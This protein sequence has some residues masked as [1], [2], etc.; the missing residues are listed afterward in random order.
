[1]KR[2]VKSNQREV[3]QLHFICSADGTALSG[4]DSKQV[5]MA[6]TGTGVKTIT[7]SEA[8]QDMV[9]QATAGTD[10]VSTVVSVTNS[11]TIVIT[12]NT[13]E[14]GAAPTDGIVHVSVTGSRVTDRY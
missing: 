8:L 13:T 6:D 9:V 14:A 11:T 1:M 2:S 3:T 5:S 7:L 10:D 4:L 12:T